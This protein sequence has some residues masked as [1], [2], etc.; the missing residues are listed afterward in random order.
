MVAVWR[1]KSS[2]AAAVAVAILLLLACTP[3]Q[4]DL[5]APRSGPGADTP[6]GQ[7]SP[8]GSMTAAATSDAVSFHPFKT[9]DT[10]SSAYQ[11]LVYAG[12]LVTRDPHNPEKFIPW[13]AESWSMADDRLTYTFQL[14]PDLR[15]SDGVSITSADFKWTF[16][17][18]LKP[19]NGYPYASNFET[20]AAY[21]APDPRTIVVTLKEPLSIGLDNADVIGPLPKHIWENLD[22]NDAGKNPEIMSPTVVSGPFKLKEWQR[23]SHA[24]FVAN[25]YYFKGRPK[26]D[27][28]T[29]Q[30]VGTQAVAFQ[31]LRT[32]EVDIAEFEPAD[33]EQAR[34]LDNVTVYEWWPAATTWNYLGY[35]LRKPYLQDVRVRRALAYAIDRHIIIDKIQYGLAAPIYSAYPPS[36]WCYNPDVPHYDYDPERARQLLAEAGWVA[37]P[38]GYVAKDGE[39]LRLRMLYGPNTSKVRERIA[40]VAQEEFRKVGVEVEVQGLEWAAFLQT[41]KAPPFD[42]DMTVLGWASTV[43]P[44]WMYQVWSEKNIPNLNSVAYVNKRVE[45]LFQEGAREFDT[46]QRKRAYQEIQKI[47]ADDE[48][49]IFLTMSKAYTGVN[50]RIGGIQPTPLGIRHNIEQWYVK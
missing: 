35:N 16:E 29:I 17:Q 8:G 9:T 22:W 49:Y 15:W 19:E 28:Y 47:L 30:I 48:P 31:K 32:G 4:P 13:L 33:I 24:T 38:D 27:S 43:E 2:R 36:C 20:I 1:A 23:D 37:G 50:N 18:A 6:P 12:G 44:H 14:R 42:W 46:E 5:N 3:S 7:W 10:A 41:I 45:E 11:A 25:D 34:R 40:T 21:E 26:L 39:R